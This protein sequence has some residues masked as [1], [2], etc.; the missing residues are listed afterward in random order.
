MRTMARSRNM[1][2]DDAG[3]YHMDS[4]YVRPFY[5]RS[6]KLPCRY[7]PVVVKD[8][9]V[10]WQEKTLLPEADLYVLVCGGKWWETDSTLQAVRYF[11]AYGRVLLLFNHM[12]KDIRLKLPGELCTLPCLYLPFFANPLKEDKGASACFGEILK[13]GTGGTKEWEGKKRGMKFWR[14]RPG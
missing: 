1:E 3:I 13:A 11:K 10:S 5:G 9:G 12:S 6:V 4:L 8:V 7:F 14:R 2:A